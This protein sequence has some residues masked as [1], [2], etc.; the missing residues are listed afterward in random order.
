MSAAQDNIRFGKATA[1]AELKK[2]N[3]KVNALFK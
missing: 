2:A 3:D 1:A